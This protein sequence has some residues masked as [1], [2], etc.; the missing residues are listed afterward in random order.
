LAKQSGNKLL[1]YTT[2]IEA[3]KT[4]GEI[5]G[6]LASKGAQSIMMDYKQGEPVAL[7]FKIAVN[8]QEVGFKLP[9]NVGGAFKAMQRMSIPPRY[10]NEEQAKRT[11]WRIVKTWVE[12]QMA[13]IECGQAEMAEVFLSYAITGTGQTLFQRIQQNPSRLLG[14]GEPETGNLIEGR[15]KASGE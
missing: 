8:G 12:A 1:N 2:E 5:M 6:I 14:E 13:L 3:I 10:A 7:S 11:A 9:C 15:F 4:A